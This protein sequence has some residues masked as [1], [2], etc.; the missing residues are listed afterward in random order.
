MRER[1]IAEIQSESIV[2]KQKT[3]LQ[4]LRCHMLYFSSVL[5]CDNIKM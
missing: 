1:A 4:E 2:N 5:P 3:A